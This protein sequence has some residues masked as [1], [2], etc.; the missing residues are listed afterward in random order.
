MTFE[1][2]E[3]ELQALVLNAL[4]E[5]AGNGAYIQKGT[6]SRVMVASRANVSDCP[7]GST[8]PGYYG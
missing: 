1:V 7:D 5:S 3:V 4:K 2:T 6:S 8:S